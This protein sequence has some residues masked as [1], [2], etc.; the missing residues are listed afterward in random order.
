MARIDPGDIESREFVADM[1]R[2]EVARRVTAS[3]RYG[4]TGNIERKEQR[5]EP[6]SVQTEVLG[7]PETTQIAE[8]VETVTTVSGDRKETTS[9]REQIIEMRTGPPVKMAAS[10]V[11]VANMARSKLTGPEDLSDQLEYNPRISDAG[12]K[13]FFGYSDRQSIRQVLNKF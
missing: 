9:H 13:N 11:A 1:S 3:R 12:L 7:A 4:D 6:I 5:I 8:K 2:Q 10:P